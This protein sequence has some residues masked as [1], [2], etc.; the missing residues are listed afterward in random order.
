MGEILEMKIKPMNRHYIHAVAIYR[1][2]EIVGH[3]PY[4]LAP[5]MSAFLMRLNKAFAEITGAKVNRGAGYGLEVLCV[6]H[7]YGPNIYVDKMKAL[8]ESVL[9]DGHYNLCNSD[10]AQLMGVAS[11]CSW[12]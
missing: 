6:Y 2:A 8:V 5:R 4:N 7:L 10:F 11:G 3:V 12:R 1:D 9:A